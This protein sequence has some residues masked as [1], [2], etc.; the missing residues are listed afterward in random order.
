MQLFTEFDVFSIEMKHSLFLL[1]YFDAK[2][3]LVH[4]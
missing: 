2:L 3:G 1:L 4:Y